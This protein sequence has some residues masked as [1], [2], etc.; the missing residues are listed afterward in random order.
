M[1]DEERLAEYA[2]GILPA[3]D[4]TAVDA[5]L[6]SSPALARELAALQEDLALAATAG[7]EPLAPSSRARLVASAGGPERFSVFV[8][9]MMRLFDLGAEAVR[10][11]LARL[12]DATSWEGSPISGVRLIHFQ[13][14]P[15]VA[16]SD[17]GFVAIEAGLRFPLHRHRGAEV[18]LVVEGTLHDEGRIHRAGDV[19]EWPADSTHQY[20]AGPGRDLILM[21]AHSGI[22]LVG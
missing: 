16:A 11:L 5:E 4:R 9:T 10:A 18:A 1:I 22:D 6:R 2:L 12:D 19:V 8:P 7:L 14:G 21:V 15:A 3:E 20:Q 17:T 13:A